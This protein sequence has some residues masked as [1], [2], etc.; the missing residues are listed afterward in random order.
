M[1]AG[2]GW[3]PSRPAARK[4][5]TFGF[6][7]WLNAIGAAVFN[8]ADRLIVNGVLGLSATGIYS[9]V[10][11]VVNK[12]VEVT[13]MPLRI[14]PPAVSA[15]EAVGDFD[16]IRNLFFR[17]TRFNAALT[18]VCTAGVLL[19]AHPI[20]V[21]MVGARMA[22]QTVPLLQLLAV[23]YAFNS[24][25][26]P[27]AW[28]TAGIN[29]PGILARWALIGSALMCISMRWLGIHYG[30]WGAAWANA[31]YL[32]TAAITVEFTGLLHISRL[33]T[34]ATMIPSILALGVCVA[35][36]SSDW[37][38]QQSIWFHL[39]FASVL[40]PP[41]L[42]A[43]LGRDLLTEIRKTVE[44]ILRRRLAFATGA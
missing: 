29:R 21:L 1:P 35:V 22:E 15:A 41:L 40:M 5:L 44:P 8:Q 24:L 4:L 42:V 9:A 34:I 27:A 20:C 31:A 11:S 39:I 7:Q 12:I 23:I 43:V 36:T 37:Y 30:L 19:F 26:L 3:A 38:M 10:M 6:A 2:S 16:R 28:F 32:V 17:A 25:C 33:R 18:F 14:L 13:F